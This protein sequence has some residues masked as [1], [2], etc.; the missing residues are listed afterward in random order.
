VRFLEMGLASAAIGFVVANAAISLLTAVL[1]RFVRSSS[2][3]ARSLFLIRMLPTLGAAIA[4]V[5]LVL[6]AYVSFEPAA[7]A[8]RAGPA[9]FV[10]VVPAGVL[11]AFAVRRTVTQWLETRR[12][13]RIWMAAGELSADVAIPV[14]SYRVRSELPLAA[15]VGVV[16]PRL[17]VSR[18]FMGALSDGERQ[19]VLDHET[20]HLRALDNLKRVVMGLAPDW[21]ALSRVGAEIERAWAASAEDEADDY[22]VRGDSARSLDLASALLKAIRFP[23]TGCAAASHF[24]DQATIARRVQ[25]LLDDARSRPGAMPSSPLPWVAIAAVLAA[26][27]VLCGPALRAVHLTTEAAIRL[28]Q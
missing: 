3:R 27:A 9:L 23:A 22:A 2:H 21:L 1:W 13:E 10:F 17:F 8:E 19:A 6:P 11:L 25:R 28:L 14:R 16:R 24:C 7:T 4:V 18:G 5:G 20:G 15:L 12:L 26:Y